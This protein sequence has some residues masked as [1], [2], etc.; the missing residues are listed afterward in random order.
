MVSQSPDHKW[1]AFKGPAE[2]KS[3][4]K[5]WRPKPS[6]P[7]HSR[8]EGCVLEP[9]LASGDKDHLPQLLNKEACNSRQTCWRWFS[10]WTRVNCFQHQIGCVE[11][12]RRVTGENC[13]YICLGGQVKGLH[14]LTVVLNNEKWSYKDTLS[15]SEY[16]VKDLRRWV[17]QYN[18][19]EKR[20]IHTDKTILCIDKQKD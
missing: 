10:N 3:Q 9:H 18:Y 15:L 14:G 11:E 5:F 12:E 7:I 8:Y 1:L 20:M 13:I 17:K 6:N 2:N 4:F 19:K 16:E